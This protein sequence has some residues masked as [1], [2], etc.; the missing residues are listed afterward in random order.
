MRDRLHTIFYW[1]NARTWISMIL[2]IVTSRDVMGTENIPK[3]GPLILT[4]NHFSVGDPPILVG[5]FPRRIVWM[6]KQEL[7]KAP[8]V[9]KLYSMGGFIPVRRFEGDLRAI[10]RSQEALRKGQVL[11]MFPEGTRSGGRLGQGEPGTALLAL[12]TGAPILPA[13]IWGTENVKLPRDLFHRTRVHVRFGKPYRLPQAARITKEQVM[14]GTEQI[15]R[16]IAALL[17]AKY[18]SQPAAETI[19]T[20]PARVKAKR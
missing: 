15:M 8:V 5:V 10:R 1:A 2:A 14:Q 11:G 6:A 7:F 19:D 12:R 20:A 9:G 4:C 17:P 3:E 18:H 13:A 16:E